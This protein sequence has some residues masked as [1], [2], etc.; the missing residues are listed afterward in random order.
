MDGFI[1][2]PLPSD[3]LKIIV[4]PFLPGKTYAYYAKAVVKN[5]E[6]ADNWESEMQ[7]LTTRAN[8]PEPPRSLMVGILTP[9]NSTTNENKK[10]HLEDKTENRAYAS[11]MPP[12][13]LPGGRKAFYKILIKRKCHKEVSYN[14]KCKKKRIIKE[15]VAQNE[16]KEINAQLNR[17]ADE[18]EKNWKN[19]ELNMYFCEKVPDNT[20]GKNFLSVKEEIIEM[21][22]KLTIDDKIEALQ[23]CETEG[24]VPIS[25]KKKKEVPTYERTD[26]EG[27]LNVYFS[28]LRHG[29]YPYNQ[30]RRLE[31]IL[32]SSFYGYLDPDVFDTPIVDD[33]VN[34]VA[35]QSDFTERKKRSLKKTL[36]AYSVLT[37]VEPNPEKHANLLEHKNFEAPLLR[38]RRQDSTSLSESSTENREH[39]INEGENEDVLKYDDQP[40]YGSWSPKDR[41]VYIKKEYGNSSDNNLIKR[42]KK[43]GEKGMFNFEPIGN[44]TSELTGFVG[45]EYLHLFEYEYKNMTKYPYPLN[46]LDPVCQQLQTNDSGKCEE[47]YFEVITYKNNHTFENLC[48]HTKYEIE[49]VACVHDWEGAVWCTSEGKKGNFTTFPYKYADV[50]RNVEIYMPASPNGS[51]WNVRVVKFDPPEYPNGNIKFYTIEYEI[52]GSKE[53]HTQCCT[54]QYYESNNRTCMLENLQGGDTK[55]RVLATSTWEANEWNYSPWVE[56][57]VIAPRNYNYEVTVACLTTL[58]II[59]GVVCVYFYKRSRAASKKPVW[60]DNLDYGPWYKPDA[61]EIPFEKIE[62]MQKIGTGHFGEVFEGLAKDVVAGESQTR[63]AIKTLHNNEN[64]ATRLEFLKEANTMKEFVAYHVVRLIGVVSQHEKPLVVMEFMSN[65]DLKNFLRNNRPEDETSGS[66]CRVVLSDAQ[67]MRM[68][69]EIADGM[70]YLTSKKFVHRD[71]AARNCLVDENLTVKVGDFG[72]ARDVYERDYYRIDRKGEMP[73]RWMSPE[74]LRDGLWDHATDVWSYGVVLWEIA[75]YAQQPYQ[76]RPHESVTKY[77]M[78][79]GF[80]SKPAGCHEILC[81]MMMYC[82]AYNPEDRPTFMKILELWEREDIDGCL[83][84]Q[85]ITNSY[86]FTTKMEASPEKLPSNDF[87]DLLGNVY[88]ETAPM[89]P[90]DPLS[91][92]DVISSKYHGN[93]AQNYEMDEIRR[94][95]SI[96]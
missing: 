16:I 95:Q 92:N 78:D 96:V 20:P 28:T 83:N 10:S 18:E 76:G 59:V 23:Y 85:F 44:E 7:Y 17:Q 35:N 93:K 53:L 88:T 75:T 79:G 77:V 14:E 30:F 43:Y 87:N 11:W 6:D 19:S 15:S 8:A 86:Y 37:D 22:A 32:R 69:I 9:N 12:N 4:D 25:F 42:V 70:A 71:L 27:F 60:E 52:E 65:G 91:I 2:V 49:V 13:G 1:R 33:N 38:K 54:L 62:I 82:F 94:E 3:K 34:D 29:H 36:E 68:C 72:L 55:A 90:I 73:V 74:S 67:K 47:E 84:D 45:S 66:D 50:V 26:F 63:V 80:L 21:H 39:D 51:D 89:L 31:K 48:H 40:K 81:E 57:T 56:F 58:I 24:P 64:T 61:Y 5:R 41:P 46:N